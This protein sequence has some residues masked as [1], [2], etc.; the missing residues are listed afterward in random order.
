M[1]QFLPV[2]DESVALVPPT[3]RPPTAVGLAM[4]P[5]EGAPN[6]KPPLA[7][8]RVRILLVVLGT[9]LI[10]GGVALSHLSLMLIPVSVLTCW[11][12]MD[13]MLAGVFGRRTRG[14]VRLEWGYPSS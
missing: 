12:G 6:R 8:P 4:L 3:R 2:P 1:A 9:G 13:G 11:L 5:P 14:L 7:P 10:T